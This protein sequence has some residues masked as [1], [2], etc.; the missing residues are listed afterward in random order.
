MDRHR[1][2]ADPYPKFHF[3][4]DLDP[5]PDPDRY[6]NDADP[7]ADP[8]SSFFY[9]CW[10]IGGKLY[11]HFQQCQLTVFFLF[12][13]CKGAILSILIAYSNFLEM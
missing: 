5:H 4:A 9:T 10:Q 13:I 7:R 3:D 6:Q 11:F 2:D 8:T 12:T 1:V